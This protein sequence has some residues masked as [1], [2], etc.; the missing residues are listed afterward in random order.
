MGQNNALKNGA[1][2]PPRGQLIG[3]EI[4]TATIF[5]ALASATT[6]CIEGMAGIGK[7]ALAVEIGYQALENNLFD[8]I[9]WAQ[10]HGGNLTF[11]KVL[12]KIA[13]ACEANIAQQRLNEKNKEEFI[14]ELLETRRCLVIVDNY[15]TV[16]ESECNSLEFFSYN[17]PNYSRFIYTCRKKTPSEAYLFHLKKLSAESTLLFIK[18][19]I[20]V[21][22]ISTMVDDALL[23]D[24]G[25]AAGN[26]PLA[27]TWAVGQ[28]AHFGS[29]IEWIIRN[30]KEGRGTIYDRMFRKAWDNIGLTARKILQAAT[31]CPASI[32]FSAINEICGIQIDETQIGVQELV[33]F[34]LL[35]S[36]REIT[37]ERRRYEMHPL[38]REYARSKLL[39]Q[40]D[41]LD[42]V[43]EKNVLYWL[44]FVEHRGDMKWNWAGY[45]EIEE[46]EENIFAA[47]AWCIQ[48]ENWQYVI[49]FR[50]Y[51]S[52][53]LSIRGLWEKR[54]ALAKHAL[55]AARLIEDQRTAAWCLVYDLA[56]VDIKR[57]DLINA[58]KKTLEALRIFKLLNHSQTKDML[59][60]AACYHHLGKIDEK[61]N[62]IDR[63]RKFYTKSRCLYSQDKEYELFLVSEL[64]VLDFMQERFD[65]AKQK[66]SEAL[67]RASLGGGKTQIVVARCNGYIGE[68][69]EREG[70]VHKAEARY[71]KALDTA[72][73]IGR[74]DE[75]ALNALRLARLIASHDRLKATRYL[76]EATTMYRQLGDQNGLFCANQLNDILLESR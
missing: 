13:G 39:Q 8:I 66:F 42:E 7:S 61:K 54:V 60:E 56:Y 10:D 35:D 47:V 14:R 73:R 15:E 68:L 58:R 17:T 11:S 3:R 19:R 65:D 45:R 4:E 26:N 53:A 21:S 59:G 69:Y 16:L 49:D 31:T 23:R 24:L 52:N 30:I 18:K 63:A 55:Q 28:V 1:S 74:A 72:R 20:E 38:T 40:K 6:V 25:K 67:E 33:G 46:E 5:H 50:N 34:C 51:L 36:N 12:D 2:L 48:K 57:G 29:S 9:V 41:L 43:W 27:I 70:E 22:D 32:T 75:I 62:N 71:E 44:R 37:E 64:A 76:S